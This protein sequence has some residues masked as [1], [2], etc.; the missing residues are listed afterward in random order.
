[1]QGHFAKTKTTP[2]VKIVEYRNFRAEFEDKVKLGNEIKIED[3]FTE[4]DYVDAIGTSKGKGFQGV[5]KRH[6][7]G[8]VG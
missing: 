2:K 4:Q 8:G 3:V 7:F 6:G 1:M 5:V